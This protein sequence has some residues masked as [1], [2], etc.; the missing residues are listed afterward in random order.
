[1]P[2][3][4]HSK[5][6]LSARG[7]IG[8]IALRMRTSAGLSQAAVAKKMGVMQ[9]AVSN[10]ESGKSENLTIEMMER[11]AAATG[12]E[13]MK[14]SSAKEKQKPYV[15][16]NDVLIVSDAVM[17]TL[18]YEVVASAVQPSSETQFDRDKA[19]Q[20]IMAVEPIIVNA[21]GSVLTAATAGVDTGR[22][23]GVNGVPD[24]ILQKLAEFELAK[25]RA[26]KE[27]AEHQRDARLRGIQ[28]GAAATGALVG[29]V[30][31]ISKLLSLW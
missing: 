26:L 24:P 28:V 21:P 27:A 30:G 23:L 11:L 10:L 9:S 6:Q 25:R 1:M 17:E 16:D 18:L 14:S 29:L 7:I 15:V 20:D 5:K 19:V 8:Q 3:K 4:L 2:T 31:L 12:H 13:F 22:I